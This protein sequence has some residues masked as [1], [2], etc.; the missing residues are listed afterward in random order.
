MRVIRTFAIIASVFFVSFATA[1]AQSAAGQPGAFLRLGA[2]ARAL[3]L[4]G[5]FSAIADDPSAGYWN[6]AGLSQLNR[7]HFS[8]THYKMSL[9]RTH[10]F[11]AGALP[12]GYS[13]T[14]GLSWIGLG[15]NGIEARSGN[16]A[17]PDFIFSNSYNALL[18]SFA[19]K[20]NPYLSL[21]LNV[22]GLYQ[23][24]YNVD[25]SG[26][27]FD[28]SF[29]V[30]PTD[31][32]R[33]GISVQDISSSVKWSTGR[34]E[35]LPL[36]YR[37]G[38]ALNVTDNLVLAVDAYKIGQDSPG[39]AWGVEYRALNL[40]PIRLGYSDQGVAAGAGVAVPLQSMD[41]SIDYAFGKDQIDGG[42]TH[43]LSIGFA[44]FKKSSTGYDVA[45]TY[46]RSSTDMSS[47][48][49]KSTV[50]GNKE[51][52]LKVLAKGLNVRT[53]PGVENEKIGVIYKDQEYKKVTAAGYWYQIE[54]EPGKYGWV[55]HKYVK[56][57]LK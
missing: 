15:V 43:K 56:E 24:L 28:A 49:D 46:R 2:G 48:P 34:K 35:T 29:L 8:A 14:I 39:L 33:F 52:Y 13:S 51:V 10:N 6:P 19:Q 44:L 12:L 27:G 42:E 45:E 57:V 11:I 55:H 31:N 22:K 40:M 32:I 30:R 26:F 23:K 36:T 47:P 21:G 4:G 37:G 38:V 41:L 17:Q 18:L 54:L 7:I 1:Q 20:I 53:G 16:T 3:A 25:A 5:A 50:K 9:D